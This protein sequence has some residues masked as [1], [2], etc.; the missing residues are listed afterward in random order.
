VGNI[1]LGQ[2]FFED[3][4]INYSLFKAQAHRYGFDEAKYFA[5]LDRVPRWSMKKVSTVMSL[6]MKFIRILFSES[7]GSANITKT[8]RESEQL[9]KTISNNLTSGMIFQLIRRDD[10]RRQFTYLS[11]AVKS[12]HGVS[13]EEVLANPESFMGNWLP[14]TWNGCIAKRKKHMLP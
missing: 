1:F 6:Y 13:P 7:Y 4:D 3:D 11:D 5:A 8:L 12:L 9:I 10:Q 2:F 14:R